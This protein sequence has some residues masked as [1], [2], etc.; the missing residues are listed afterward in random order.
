ME[1]LRKE[2][3]QLT[4]QLSKEKEESSKLQQTCVEYEKMTHELREHNTRV[5]QSV[6]MLKKQ[7]EEDNERR[8]QEAAI[9]KDLEK[10]LQAQVNE[11][12]RERERGRERERERERYY[13]FVC[14]FFS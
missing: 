1:S 11:R 3:I 5:M 14:F 9:R 12:E 6:E 2:I 13:H 8:E 4:E 10:E 7:M